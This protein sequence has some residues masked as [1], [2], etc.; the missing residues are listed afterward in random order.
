MRV[1]KFTT[2]IFFTLAIIT[3]SCAEQGNTYELSTALSE[4][5]FYSTSDEI[6][7]L[8]PPNSQNCQ[9][10]FILANAWREKKELKK[11]MMYYANSCFDKKYN[12]NLRLFPQP[13]YSFVEVSKGRSI[14]FSDSAYQIAS[15]F[16]EYGE[17]EY[18]LKFTSLVDDDRSALYRDSV[19]L[20]SKSLQKLNRLTKAA[21]E[22]KKLASSYR[23]PGSQYMIQMRLGAV[24]ESAGDFQRA[25]DSYINV[26]KSESG[27]WQNEAAA[28]RITFLVTEKRIRIEDAEKNAY[29]AQGLFDSKDYDRA[30]NVADSIHQ[31]ERPLIAE[32]VKIKCLTLKSQSKAISFLKER[33]GKPGYEELLLEHANTLW[34]RGNKYEAVKSYDRLTS[35]SNREISER[36][37]QRLSFF[38]EERNRPELVK[39]MELYIKRFPD[40]PESGRFAWLS[41]RY[42]MK[43]G[44][45]SR[46]NEYFTRGIKNYP[47]SSYTSYCRFWQNKLK[48]PGKKDD[49]DH[50]LEELAVHNPDTYH[51]LTLLKQRADR[52]ESSK[53]IELYSAAK[54]DGNINRMRLYHSLLFIKTGYNQA[55]AERAKQINSSLKERYREAH[56]LFSSPGYSGNYKRLLEKIEAYF[57]AGDISSV[58]REI[59]II[60]DNDQESQRDAALALTLYS[61]RHHY[62]NYASFYGFKLLGHMKLKENLSLLPEEF[63]KA[64]YPY[65]FKDCVNRESKSF[66][67]RNSLLLSL[68]K[69]E[70]NF[71]YNAVSP[72]GAKGLMQLMPPTAR[73]I[74][75]ELKIHSYDLSDPCTS[76]RFG[77]HYI[78]WLDRYYHGQIEFMVAGYNAGAGNVDRWRANTKNKDMDFFSEFTPF[79]ETRDYIF[80][81]KK[82]LVQYESVYKN[83]RQ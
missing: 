54:K 35:S 12:F 3:L 79:D 47:D 38:Y 51:A 77:A 18:V 41:G 59:G 45:N 58:N 42:Y 49:P 24:Y 61:I 33:E 46:A 52:S 82:Y 43:S 34:G 40:R 7:E 9:L 11:A 75:N 30:V 8:S 68:M 22:L 57:Y 25:V 13:V 4:K 10:N 16:Y 19:I 62:Y 65:A 67:V 64:L 66:N 29:Y 50:L 74:A 73:G 70:S 23:D 26:I 27:E 5:A 44:N 36:V 55:C 56:S 1:N 28:K 32:I 14:F 53:L 71:N 15:I 17:H 78:A 48:L 80:R 21:D 72:V 39:Y 2:V 76:I 69:V 6:I 37:L 81:T 83:S 63:S 31:K 20:R 60:P